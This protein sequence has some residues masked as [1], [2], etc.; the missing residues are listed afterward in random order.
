MKYFLLIAGINY[1]PSSDTGDWK[2]TFHTREEAE[3]AVRKVPSR[4]FGYVIDDRE[5]E[6]YE[7]VDLREWIG[8]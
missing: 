3:A 8:E 6:W 4:C 7:I 5:Y 2:K 1:Y